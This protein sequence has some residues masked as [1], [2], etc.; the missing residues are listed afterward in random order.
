[1]RFKNLRSK[2]GSISEMPPALFLLFFFAVFPMLNLIFLGLI[3]ASCVTLNNIEL[4]EAA[5]TPSSQITAVFAELQNNWLTSGFGHLTGSAGPESEVSYMAIGTDPYVS[6]S[7][8]FTVKPFL[9][10]PIFKGVPAL[11]SPW[12]FQVVGKRILENANYASQ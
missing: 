1:M 6:V 4:R 11:G 3:F 2:S 5:R 7:T 9:P 10:I 12:S 8:T